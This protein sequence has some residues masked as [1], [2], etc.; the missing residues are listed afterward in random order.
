MSGDIFVDKLIDVSVTGSVVRLHFANL[1]LNNSDPEGQHALSPSQRLIMPID[2]FLQL[3]ETINQ[4]LQIMIEKG[5][6]IK[7]DDS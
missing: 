2:S 7:R 5:T 6:I 4:M 3:S 1:T